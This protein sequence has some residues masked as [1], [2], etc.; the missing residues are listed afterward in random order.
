MEDLPVELYQWKEIP[1]LIQAQ[2]TCLDYFLNC[3]AL[4]KTI[5]DSTTN[6]FAMKGQCQVYHFENTI[7]WLADNKEYPL[8]SSKKFFLVTRNVRIIS[9]TIQQYNNT[10][11]YCSVCLTY[12]FL[13]FF[14]DYNVQGNYQCHGNTFQYI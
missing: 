10:T 14:P 9:T 2:A 1:F 4:L 7:I 13:P 3:E 8:F 11:T 6:V 5:Q 12:L